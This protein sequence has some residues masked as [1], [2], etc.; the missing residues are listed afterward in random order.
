MADDTALPPNPH[1]RDP[2]PRSLAIP[3]GI[4]FGVSPNSW[5]LAYASNKQFLFLVLRTPST[6]MGVPF[7]KPAAI[8]LGST[9]IEAAE[10]M[11]DR[12]ELIVPQ[13]IPP[14][15]RTLRQQ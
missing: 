4:T 15:P 12:S 11:P 9:L 13:L 3:D 2:D 7:E 14:D 6:M 10:Q 8:K 5:R 1:D